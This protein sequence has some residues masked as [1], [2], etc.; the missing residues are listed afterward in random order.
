MKLYYEITGKGYPIFLLHGNGENH[1]IFDNL[2]K[3][4]SKS[5]Q[6]ISVDSR[7]HGNSEHSGELTYEAMV[8][9]IKE[10]A[11]ELNVNEYDVI[12]FSDGGIIAL[13]LSLED[14]RLKHMVTIGANTHVK[15]LK[16][17]ILYTMYIERIFL[18]F[19]SIYH[20]K[21]RLKLKHLNLMLKQK[22]ISYDSLKDVRIP[23]LILCGEHDMIKLSDSENIAESL[24]YG[25]LKVIPQGNHFLLSD[26][27]KSTSKEIMMFLNAC[28]REN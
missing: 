28:H 3:V 18:M 8:D 26:A 13:M 16:P 5:Y 17:I 25:I 10:L 21:A 15:A 20:P 11:S 22:T 2:V 7:Y 19:F 23:S 14:K 6:C 27:F 9:D 4:L 12:G 1:H 24:P